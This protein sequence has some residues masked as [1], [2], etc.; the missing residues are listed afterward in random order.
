FLPAATEL[1]SAKAPEATFASERR[2]RAALQNKAAC[3]P[4]RGA[5]KRTD[6]RH[7]RAIQRTPAALRASWEGPDASEKCVVEYP[8]GQCPRRT[9]SKPARRGSCGKPQHPVRRVGFEEIRGRDC[10]GA[11]WLPEARQPN[12][13][14]QADFLCSL[15][16]H[17]GD[18][19]PRDGAAGSA[20]LMHESHEQLEAGG[21]DPLHGR[22]V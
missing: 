5:V 1:M 3:P 18:S 16:Q 7:L 2:S 10:R 9:I 17:S 6:V 14:D 11:C 8:E 15:A 19:S 21:I 13:L 4:P 12:G 22:A 20:P